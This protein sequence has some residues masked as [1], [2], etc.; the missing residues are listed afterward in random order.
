[1]YESN[2]FLAILQKSIMDI[3]ISIY[4]LSSIRKFYRNSIIIVPI[5]SIKEDLQFLAII[6][7]IFTCVIII[8]E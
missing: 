3:Y 7:V 1:M 8:F 6:L 4:F 2:Y 5:R